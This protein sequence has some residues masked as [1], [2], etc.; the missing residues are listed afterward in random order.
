MV[1]HTRL[2]VKQ[3]ENVLFN[4]CSAEDALICTRAHFTYMHAALKHFS[5]TFSH[6]LCS[7]VVS[8]LHRDDGPDL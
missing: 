4:T 2:G 7:A 1:P 6:L 5:V 8:V 3:P